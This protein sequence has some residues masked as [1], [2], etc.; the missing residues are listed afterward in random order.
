MGHNLYGGASMAAYIDE[1]RGFD[2]ENLTYST[3]HKD[4]IQ[5]TEEEFNKMLVIEDL[6][7]RLLFVNIR[8]LKKSFDNM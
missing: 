3:R 4:V 5:L 2:R 6:F 1:N 7:N 8:D